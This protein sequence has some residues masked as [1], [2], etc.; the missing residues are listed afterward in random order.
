MIKNESRRNEI[1]CCCGRVE[2]EICRLRCATFIPLSI[3]YDRVIGVPA[4][5]SIIINRLE[6]KLLHF[7]RIIIPC[8]FSP[9]SDGEY[10]FVDPESKL[11]KY[12]PKSWR[13]SHT[14]VSFSFLG[15]LWG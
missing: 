10:M 4:L 9:L 1:N 6:R 3:N 5:F 13:S 2:V 12:G 11:S 14:H 15:L 8:H 7:D